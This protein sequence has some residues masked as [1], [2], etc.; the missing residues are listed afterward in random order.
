MEFE[1]T[2][3]EP[4]T[5][6]ESIQYYAAGLALIAIAAIM[7]Y[8]VVMRYFFSRAPLWGEDVPR[9]LFVWLTLLSAGVAI[10]LGLNV[11]VTSFIDRMPTKLRRA[12]EVSMHLIVLAMLAV[13]FWFSFPIIRLG[14]GG[15][16]LST[17][18]SEAVLSLPIPV[19]A[20]IM[21]YYQSLRLI[22][23][24]RQA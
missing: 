2:Q 21:F 18:W 10:R 16:M 5:L 1:T 14:L 6:V 20:A 11:R 12:V 7:M 22:D 13:L 19:G 8:T 9:V 15:T 23:S 17:G 4:K 24:W 3:A